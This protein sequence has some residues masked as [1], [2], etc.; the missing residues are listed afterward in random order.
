M[1]RNIYFSIFSILLS[2]FLALVYVWVYLLLEHEDPDRNS[3]ISNETESFEDYKIFCSS[4]YNFPEPLKE[5][6][7]LLTPTSIVLLFIMLLFF[8][9]TSKKE[10]KLRLNS[11]FM[12]ENRFY[13]SMGFCLLS[14]ELVDI[15]FKRVEDITGME[16][17]SFFEV[18]LEV[19]YQ[20]ID[21]FVIGCRYMP[22]LIGLNSRHFLISILIGV[23][24]TLVIIV[25]LYDEVICQNRALFDN[26]GKESNIMTNF[27]INIRSCLNFVYS[28]L[29]FYLAIFLIFNKTFEIIIKKRNSVKNHYTVALKPVNLEDKKEYLIFSAY[30]LSYCK[31]LLKSNKSK[32][33]LEK[34]SL[35]QMLK[36]PNYLLARLLD[37]TGELVKKIYDPNSGFRYSLRFIC[38]QLTY[39]C[40]SIF[41]SF[42]LMLSFMRFLSPVILN[43]LSS[44]LNF[45]NLSLIR[46]F[47]NLSSSGILFCKIKLK[48]INEFCTPGGYFMTLPPI[49][50]IDVNLYFWFAFLLPIIFTFLL[51][52][53]HFVQNFKNYKQD[54]LSMCKGK[55]KLIS[56][57]FSNF[58]IL[59]SCLKFTGFFLGNLKYLRKF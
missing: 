7:I 11:L 41:L 54:F 38:T 52:L 35:I 53:F 18:L 57:E 30:D 21:V 58:E 27:K 56:K 10:L 16:L 42:Y 3:T 4:N 6:N 47:S 23:Y 51:S 39:L 49:R 1:N 44:D 50:D 31:K 17:K 55:S 8:W 59:E 43:D 32:Q 2:F 26:F 15:W 48:F 36:S 13:Y 25:S 22:I 19:L 24:L 40:C 33:E 46:N 29:G 9:K 28:F 12:K 5:M 14:L 20:F 34:R 37:S 45:E